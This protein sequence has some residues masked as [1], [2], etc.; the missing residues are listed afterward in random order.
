MRNAGKAPNTSHA[1]CS[2]IRILLAWADS[3]RISL[4]ERFR[5]QQFLTLAEAESLRNY[6]QSRVSI[7]VDTSA[8]PRDDTLPINTSRRLESARARLGATQ[9]CVSNV[10]LYNRLT[11]ITAFV[12][13]LALHSSESHSAEVRPQIPSQSRIF[14]KRGLS[15]EASTR[16]VQLTDATSE[17]NPFE[18]FVR[19]RNELIILLLISLGMRSGELLALKVT[20]FA[21]QENEV[22]IPRRHGDPSDPR[23]DQPVAKT[24]D[25]R[26]PLTAQLT[27][28][29]FDYVM[30]ERNHFPVAQKHA[31]LFVTHSPGK[32]QGAP[33]SK[34]G[35]DKVFA[36]IRKAAPDVLGGFT[37]HSLRHTANDNF[38]RLA[39]RNKLSTAAEEKQRSY[40][41]GWKDGSGTAPT[42]TRRYIEEQAKAAMLQLQ[43]T[44]TGR[45]KK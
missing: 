29:V 10:T 2:A 12:K 27:D 24:M 11:Y 20:G 41:M 35:L 17:E 39:E 28:A 25:R 14:A 7:R 23:T 18:E 5:R 33:L 15:K 36:K 37:A 40:A 31:F 1:A 19:S 4:D 16:L 34:P 38:S 26:L 13:W 6:L 44:W 30:K 42:Y 43:Q 22:V 3:R 9:N 32:H 21:F 8:S 45:A